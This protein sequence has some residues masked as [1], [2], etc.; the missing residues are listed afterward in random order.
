M[1]MNLFQTMVY[2]LVSGI[3]EILP[4]SSQAHRLL[5]L[6][7]FGQ[8]RE[9]ELL[10]LL[11]DLWVLAALYVGCQTNIV[12]I[13][14]A[15][16]LARIPKSRRKR[17]LDTKSLMD[18]RM[19][20]TMLIPVIIVSSF[21]QKLSTLVTSMLVMALLLFLNGLVLYIPQ[22]L[23]GS[24]RDSR[25]LSRVEGFAMGLSGTLSVIPGFSGVGAAVS[26]GSV[27]GVERSYALDM[28][29][30]MDISVCIGFVIY[31]LLGLVSSGIGMLSFSMFVSY[32]LAA[33]AAFGTA[34]LGIKVMRGLAS[35]TGYSCFAYYCWGLALFTF[36]MNLLA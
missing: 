28:T 12:R 15:R 36:I 23:P 17:P 9:P 11:I 22:F 13:L 27:C 16:R 8:S 2:G 19:R 26:V 32:I 31:D 7:L 29:L 10:R 21:Y 25:T 24:N 34:T 3:A 6:K 4:I 20:R 5:I 1:D 33:V 18:S 30:M 14:R 35:D